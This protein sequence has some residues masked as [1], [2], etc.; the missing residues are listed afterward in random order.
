M[1]TNV[2]RGVEF[3]HELPALFRQFTCA[4]GVIKNHGA[5]S[6]AALGF[7]PRNFVAVCILPAA[8]R[9]LSMSNWTNLR[10]LAPIK[11]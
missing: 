9:S 6:N 7:S 10:L 1:R 4:L 5:L 2:A 8:G 3:F 11:N